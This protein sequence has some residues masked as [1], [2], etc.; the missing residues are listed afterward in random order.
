MF[1]HTYCWDIT[2]GNCLRL[3]PSRVSGKTFKW[4]LAAEWVPKRENHQQCFVNTDS[5]DPTAPLPLHAPHPLPTTPLVACSLAGL[6][7]SAC[8]KGRYWNLS[9][10]S[11]KL[12]LKA[13]AAAQRGWMLWSEVLPT[14]QV[15]SKA[16][17]LLFAMCQAQ[18][19]RNVQA[20]LEYRLLFTGPSWVQQS[21]PEISFV[22]SVSSER[23]IAKGQRDF[24][25]QSE[26]ER[27]WWSRAFNHTQEWSTEQTAKTPDWVSA[28][29]V[30]IYCL[31]T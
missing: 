6:E 13:R 18:E 27:T 28:K 12:E 22:D 24:P 23:Q 21:H 25:P 3:W 14:S 30:P 10:G 26:K 2:Y 5:Q 29:F 16:W 15:C 11:Q 31:E 1:L 4:G 19:F 17:L 9:R 20:Q 8:Y 7:E